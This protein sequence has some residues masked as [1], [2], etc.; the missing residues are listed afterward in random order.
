MQ[1]EITENDLYT[2]LE[3]AKEEIWR[4]WNNNNLRKKVADFIGEIPAHMQ[5]NPEA[6]L[7]KNIATINKECARFIEVAAQTGLSPIIWEYLDDKFVDCNKDKLGLGKMAFLNGKDRKSQPIIQYQTIIRVEACNSR[8]FRHIETLW[9]EDFIRFHHRLLTQSSFDGF[10]FDGSAWFGSKGGSA[11]KYYPYFLALFICHGIL[12][13]NFITNEEE[14]EER[15]SRSVV[16]PAFRQVVDHFG[17][18]P[19]I[20]PLAPHD[21]ASDIYWRCYPAELEAEVL[22]C[23]SKCKAKDSSGHHHE[24]RCNSDYYG[25]KRDKK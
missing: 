3:E 6:V 2:S 15:F 17:I 16:F 19:L 14:P 9:G 23:L 21:T 8:P 18:K 1:N 24:G 13:E 4:R 20:V 11:K 7:D 12:F 5:K 25:S 10:L 22:R